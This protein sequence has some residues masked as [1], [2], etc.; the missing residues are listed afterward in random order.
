LRKNVTPEV[1]VPRSAYSTVF[2]TAIVSTCTHR[3]V[4]GREQHPQ[5]DRH[6][7]DVPA[8][9]VQN[10]RLGGGV[11]AFLGDGHEVTITP[12]RR[13]RTWDGP[14]ERYPRSGLRRSR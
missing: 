9:R 10:G 6:E 14:P 7:G 3:L 12:A 1:A 5:H 13:P 11:S 2:C 4:Q 8:A